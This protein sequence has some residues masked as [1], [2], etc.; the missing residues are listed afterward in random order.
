MKKRNFVKESFANR[1]REGQEKGA[2]QES[3]RQ[4]NE[5]FLLFHFLNYVAYTEMLYAIDDME[6]KGL[7]RQKVKMN[8][9]EIEKAWNLYQH[10][11]K[12]SMNESAWF[13][14]QDYCVLSHQNLE[15]HIKHL[16]GCFIDYLLKENNTKKN[17][18]IAQIAVCCVFRYISAQ[19]WER[20][21]EKFREQCGIDFSTMFSFAKMDVLTVNSKNILD[22]FIKSYFSLQS[23]CEY[24]PC[25]EAISMIEEK[26]ADKDLF[27]NAACKAINMSDTYR[28]D[29]EKYIKQKDEVLS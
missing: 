11:V 22:E 18:I 7:Y 2:I 10:A 26:M 1:L 29:Y 24:E 9:K 3:F 23:M 28:D 21:F 19:L 15:C 25:L 13:L 27:D 14:M 8:W 20:F 6:E 16:K 4:C 17:D 12:R 5:Q